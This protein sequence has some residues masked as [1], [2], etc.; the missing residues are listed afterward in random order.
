MEG[1]DIKTIVYGTTIFVDSIQVELEYGTFMSYTFQD[2]I[3]KSYIIVFK[4]LIMHYPFS[5]S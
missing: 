4:E 1:D 2:L 5:W 3:N